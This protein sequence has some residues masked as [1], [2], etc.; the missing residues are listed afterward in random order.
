MREKA[1]KMGRRGQSEVNKKDRRKQAKLAVH[2]SSSLKGIP[3]RFPGVST[4]VSRRLCPKSF[5]FAKAT[6]A[7]T[8]SNS[9]RR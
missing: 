8:D 6:F 7:A 1:T 4:R 3:A 2:C 9:C 5:A